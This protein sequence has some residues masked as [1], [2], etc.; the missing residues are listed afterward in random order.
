MASGPTQPVV[1]DATVLSNFASSDAVTWLGDVL[2]RPVTVPTVQSELERGYEEGHAFLANAVDPLGGV[3]DVVETG[4][5]VATP[6][7]S[8]V[9]ERLDP[10]EAEALLQAHQADGT[11]ATDDLAAR[12]LAETRD[13]PV[14]GSIGLLALGV[15]R[16]SLDVATA[17]EWLS[18]WRSERGYYAPVDH[19]ENLLRGDDG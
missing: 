17:N 6:D 12:R 14:T 4:T 19:V 15:D 18:T 10:G 3:I 8:A 13:V 7:R 9:R 1:L 2:V 11:L 5:A 16:G